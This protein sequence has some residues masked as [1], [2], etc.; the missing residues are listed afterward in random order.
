MA[1]LIPNTS[2]AL[3][4]DAIQTAVIRAQE[5][6]GQFPDEMSV[7]SWVAAMDEHINGSVQEGVTTVSI[8]RG[9]PRLAQAGLH[10][11]PFTSA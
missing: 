10:A 9:S 5:L 2:P 4:S 11:M 7:I 3:T 6:Q 1:I 8:D